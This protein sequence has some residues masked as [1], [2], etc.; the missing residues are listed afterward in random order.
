MANLMDHNISYSVA[1]RTLGTAGEKYKVL[2]ESLS[3]Q[4]I[5]PEEIFVFIADGYGLPKESMGIERYVYVK[6]GMLAQRALNY[7]QISSEYILFTDDDIKFADDEV[8]KMFGHLIQNDAD[9]ISPD[10][11]ENANRSALS[12]MM[13]MMSGR[14]MPRWNDECW[15]YKVMSTSGYSYNKKIRKNVYRS[16]TNAGACFLC[17]KEDFLKAHIEDELWVDNTPYP[18]GEDQVMYY[19]MHLSGLKILTY[20]DHR[21]EHLDGGNNLSKDKEKMLIYSDFRFKTIFWHRFIFKQQKNIFKKI[22]VT[23]S[24]GYVCVFTL[25]IALLKLRFDILKVKVAAIKDAVS[26]LRCSEYKNLPKIC[27]PK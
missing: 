14:M 18:L 25:L 23:L 13:M 20:Y 8:E 22:W 12:E 17:R 26:F 3:R 15:G 21:V 6:K 9:V 10:I 7:E 5:A 2:L 24:F 16:E 11:F 1:I 4:T 27:F 19:K